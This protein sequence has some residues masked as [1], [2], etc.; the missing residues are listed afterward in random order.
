MEIAR[1][2]FGE[3][4]EVASR[5][6]DILASRGVEWGLIGPRE[7]DRLWPRHVLNSV[8]IATLVPEGSTVVD[9]GS[10]PGLP[11]VPLAILRPDLSVTLLEP[12]LR[13]AEFLTGV[14]DELDLGGSVTVVR[15]RAEE[16][17]QRFDVV[18][19][20]AVAALP[21]LL[22]WCLPLIARD[23]QL[24]AL[25]GES[26]EREL[27]ESKRLLRQRGRT[28]EVLTVSAAAGVDPTWVIR[29]R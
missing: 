9:V 12:L 21:K 2:V 1:E 8:A 26:A 23:G 20:R 18:T 7:S 16:Q 11:G 10:G 13:R 4:Y 29:V 28:G 24:L 27:V 3:H 25:K 15:G 17:R 5:Y 6:V 14:V 19:A 22:G